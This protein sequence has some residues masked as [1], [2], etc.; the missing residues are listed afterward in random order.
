[1]SPCSLIKAHVL[2]PRDRIRAE[3]YERQSDGSW[4][5]SEVSGIEGVLTLS[6]IGVDLPLAEIYDR[7][8]F[9]D[10]PGT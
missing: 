8:K 7:V 4:R 6:A 10:T 9:E 2:I 5:F 3:I 1:L